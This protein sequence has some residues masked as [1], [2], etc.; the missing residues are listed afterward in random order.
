MKGQPKLRI[1]R[2]MMPRELCKRSKALQ[3]MGYSTKLYYYDFQN[4][5][6]VNDLE[7][8]QSHSYIL[9]SIF[10]YSE[11]LG[12]PIPSQKL[13]EISGG[14]FVQIEVIVPVRVGDLW[15]DYECDYF[16]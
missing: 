11:I 5:Q 12:E 8:L 3:P 14:D 13:L 9:L 16:T 10:G 15:S 7:I 4:L 2:L 1:L 6:K